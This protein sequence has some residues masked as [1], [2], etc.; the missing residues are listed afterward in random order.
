[1]LNVDELTREND[2]IVKR[3]CNVI[4]ISN[5]LRLSC[6]RKGEKNLNLK[7]DNYFIMENGKPIK[8]TNQK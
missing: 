7:G 3:S 6:D 8:K 5:D 2:A 1:M 4:K